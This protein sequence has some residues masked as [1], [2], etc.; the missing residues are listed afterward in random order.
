MKI[1]LIRSK[2]GCSKNQRKIL[3][4]LGLRKIN[5]VKEH[6][7]SNVILGMVY[8]VKHLVEVNYQ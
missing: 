1:K 3:Q 5:Q 6:Y 7:N 8:K 2:I 4:A